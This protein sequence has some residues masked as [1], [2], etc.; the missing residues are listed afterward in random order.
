MKIVQKSLIFTTSAMLS[1]L[2]DLNARD[3]SGQTVFFVAYR[4]GQ[5]IDLNVRDQSEW[6]PIFELVRKDT[7]KLSN[8]P[9]TLL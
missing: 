9:K 7:N 4:K 6:T 3:N 1:N 5:N 8:H 2:C